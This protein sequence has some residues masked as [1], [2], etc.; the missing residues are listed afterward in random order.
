MLNQLN[1]KWIRRQGSA[2]L[3][4]MATWRFFADR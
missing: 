3:V 1:Q 4:H 2:P